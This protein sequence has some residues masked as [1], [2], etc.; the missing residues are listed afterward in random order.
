MLEGIAVLFGWFVLFFIAQN[1]VN[2]ECIEKSS[3]VLELGSLLQIVISD[4]HLMT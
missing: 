2:E 1:A 3:L 4:L